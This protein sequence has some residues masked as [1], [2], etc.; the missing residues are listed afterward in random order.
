MTL[1]ARV[2]GGEGVHDLKRERPYLDG[3]PCDGPASEVSKTM[4][5]DLGINESIVP[6]A[7]QSTGQHQT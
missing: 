5:A 2:K 1:G 4:V 6:P 7:R 3:I